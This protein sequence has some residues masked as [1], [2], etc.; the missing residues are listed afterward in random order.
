MAKVHSES[1]NQRI[2]ELT[3]QQVSVDP[4]ML[5]G[6]RQIPGSGLDLAIQTEQNWIY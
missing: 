1:A 4:K 5:R 6:D 2:Y 3:N